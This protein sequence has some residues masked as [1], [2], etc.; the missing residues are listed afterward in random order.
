MTRDLRR[1]QQHSRALCGRAI[2]LSV[3]CSRCVVEKGRQTC[4][5]TTVTHRP[6]T[7]CNTH[8]HSVLCDSVFC[9]CGRGGL[10]V[11]CHTREKT[12]GGGVWGRVR[13]GSAR[14]HSSVNHLH[15]HTMCPHSS[16]STDT[17]PMFQWDEVCT[18]TDAHKYFFSTHVSV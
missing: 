6:F 11:S 3:P 14:E 8:S 7:H 15:S 16:E 17:Q 18:S 10:I 5:H 2:N 12:S 1:H 9:V 13:D 4:P